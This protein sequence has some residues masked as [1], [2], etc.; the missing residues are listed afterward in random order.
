M[1]NLLTFNEYIK[2]QAAPGAVSAGGG[3]VAYS[4]LNSNGMGRVVAPT[5]GSTPGSVW[6]SGS[7]TIGSGDVPKNFGTK[8]GLKINKEQKNKKKRKKQR[9][10]V[11][12]YT[13][14]F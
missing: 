13:K 2:E 6:G 14:P 9:D 4:T 12:Y 3:G 11:R 10:T 8:F 1:K 5:V 7:G